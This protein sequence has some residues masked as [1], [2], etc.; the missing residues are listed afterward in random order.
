[1]SG[2]IATAALGIFPLSAAGGTAI[3]ANAALTGVTGSTI[4]NL[5]TVA[6]TNALTTAVTP[7]LYVNVGTAVAT[8]TCDI[9]V[10]GYDLT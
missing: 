4:V 9:F 7:I 8:G 3:V 10:Y 6:S 5:R 2:S 1:V